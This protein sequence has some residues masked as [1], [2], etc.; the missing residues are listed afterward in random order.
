L[1]GREC[2]YGWQQLAFPVPAFD[3]R[4]RDHIAQSEVNR[5]AGLRHL[6]S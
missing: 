2:A 6:G 1:L 4:I 5:A 3:Y